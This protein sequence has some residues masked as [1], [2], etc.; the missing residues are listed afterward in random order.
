MR[1][2]RLEA[3]GALAMREIPRPTAGAGEILVRV[4]AAGICGSDRHMFR[5][6]YPTGRPVTLGHEFCGV[7]E[8]VGASVTGFDGGE[9]V[10]V[11]P[12]IAC[13]ACRACHEGRPNLCDNLLAIGVFRDGGFAEFV[14]VP[15]L[16]A[17]LLPPGLDPVHGAFSEPL[18]CCLHALDVA[19]I[20]PGGSV[21]ILGG[22]VIGLLMVQLARVAGAGEVF[23]VTRQEARRALAME[24]GATATVDPASGDVVAS[25]RRMSGQGVDVVLE[26]AGVPETLQQGLKMLRKGG[27]LV[28]FGVTPDGVAVPVRPFDLLVNEIRL[29][30]AYLNPHTH[31]RAAAMVASGVLELDR[32]V[33]HQV[34]LDAV[35]AIVGAPPQPGEIKVIVT[36]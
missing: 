34:G 21:A 36:P 31:A 14:A 27:T 35:A 13:N 9:L 22:G 18:A 16:Q 25:V 23:L 32:L 30:A 15:A 12:N 19:R 4:L 20:V 5:G 2:V 6:E 29:E 28:L 33:T 24:L 3:L 1:A 11:D 17:H 8:A 7:V 10:T 26:C